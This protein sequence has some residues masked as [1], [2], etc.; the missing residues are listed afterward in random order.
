RDDVMEPLRTLQGPDDSRRRAFDNSND[1]SFF[2]PGH[3]ARG[4][5]GAD[6]ESYDNAIARQSDS[7]VGGCHKDV[8]LSFV[9]ANHVRA[10]VAMEFNATCDELRCLRQDI[11]VLADAGD[12][13]VDFEFAK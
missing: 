1:A 7:G 10:A 12:G 2:L 9:F 3:G 6:V 11:A 5:L 8:A 13:A 4:R